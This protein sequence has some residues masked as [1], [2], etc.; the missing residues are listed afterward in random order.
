MRACTCFRLLD[1]RAVF[2]T[3]I[4][5]V[6]AVLLV[7]SEARADRLSIGV[8]FSSPGVSVSGS[9]GYQPLFFPWGVWSYRPDTHWLIRNGYYV[10]PPSVR[11]IHY[12][13]YGYGYGRYPA[14]DRGLHRG[15]DRGH[16]YFDRTW[17]DG[18]RQRGG[19]RDHRGR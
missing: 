12:Q 16:R 7:S 3:F 19:D 14:H 2:R 8:S 9:Y 10:S 15:H 6:V 1:S 4:A 5:M 18:H 17:D 11:V 13:P